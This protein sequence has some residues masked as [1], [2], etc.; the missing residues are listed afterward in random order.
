MSP[1]SLQLECRFLTSELSQ[2][3][4]DT[5]VAPLCVSDALRPE[6]LIIYVWVIFQPCHLVSQSIL[7]V[8]FMAVLKHFESL[9]STI[10]FERENVIPSV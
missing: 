4:E 1:G 6:W 2:A 8:L 5:I 10:Q 9:I 3:H 7:S